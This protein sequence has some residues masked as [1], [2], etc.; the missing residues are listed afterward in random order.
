VSRVNL[1]AWALEHPQMIAFLLALLSF[2]GLLAYGRLGQK[3]DPEF[4][5]KAMLVQAYWPG[6]SAQQMAD[7]VT[8]KL[9]KKLQEVAEIDYT[10]SYSKP[11]VTQITIA[12]REETAPAAV[13]GVWYQV[14]KKLGDIQHTLPQGVRGPFFNDEFGDTFGNLYA[15]TGEGFSYR[16]LRDYADAARNEFLRVPDVNKVELIGVQDER[17]YV[18]AS[19]AKLASLGIDPQLIAGTLVATNAVAAA[20]TVQ[21][22]AEQVRLTVSG[23]FDSVESIRN[24]GI[25][26]GDRVFRLGDIAEVRRA[27]IDPATSKMRYNGREAIGLA[28]S[29]RKGG[30]VLRLGAQLEATVKRV[31]ASLPVGVEVQAV[32][33]QP[34]VVEESVHE[35]KKSLGEAVW[36]RSASRWSSRSPS[37]ACTSSASSCSASPWARSSSPS[38]CWSTTRSSRWR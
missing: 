5:V 4:T 28:V 19:N 23:E 32:S 10:T 36:S 38:A 34:R 6:S 29:M 9:E 1:S 13:P 35:F 25:R 3:E 11:G 15:I 12:L 26:A 8:D 27:P 33:D 37:C 18:E 20:G 24:I 2:A 30:D 7:Q 21:T 31:R 17:I 14:R 22:A 16:E